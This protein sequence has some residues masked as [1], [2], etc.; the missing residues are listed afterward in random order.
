MQQN[1]VVNMDFFI[2]LE[3]IVCES[4]IMAHTVFSEMEIMTEN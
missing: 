3:S 1:S 2:P 4:G